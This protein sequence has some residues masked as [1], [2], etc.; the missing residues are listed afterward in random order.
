[1]G[2]FKS[3]ADLE[4]NPLTVLVKAGKDLKDTKPDFNFELPEDIQI[5]STY[6]ALVKINIPYINSPRKY[7]IGD[8]KGR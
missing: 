6:Y 5:N 3:G 1:M 4:H 8:S 7:A 2:R